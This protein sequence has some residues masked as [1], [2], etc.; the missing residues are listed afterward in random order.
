MTL[1]KYIYKTKDI[2]MAIVKQN[3]FNYLVTFIPTK[4]R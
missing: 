1:C 4:S 3:A 2:W